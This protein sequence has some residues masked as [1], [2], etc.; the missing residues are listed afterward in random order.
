MDI[1]EGKR[2]E[3]E[4]KGE[5]T[6]RGE[7]ENEKRGKEAEGKKEGRVRMPEGDERGEGSASWKREKRERE[8]LRVCR[9]G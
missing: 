2:R 4:L 8:T 6:E 5:E 3:G 9:A 7:G 1:G